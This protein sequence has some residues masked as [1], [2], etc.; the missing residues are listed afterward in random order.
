MF[1]FSAIIAPPA[2]PMKLIKFSKHGPRIDA[3]KQIFIFNI[4][5]VLTKQTSLKNTQFCLSDV[6]N[7]QI[8]NEFWEKNSNLKS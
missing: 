8:P 1:D 4:H 2:H 7:L 3:K 6:S 5:I